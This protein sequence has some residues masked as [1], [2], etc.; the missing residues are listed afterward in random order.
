MFNIH[1][2]N[3]YAEFLQK[4]IEPLRPLRLVFDCSDGTTG[5]IISKLKFKNCEVK[6]INAE[7]DGNFPNHGPNP[8][9]PKAIRAL[10]A[11][12]KDFQA[13][14]GVIFD[15]DGDRAFFT[16]DK[17]HLINPDAIARLL[18]HYLKPQK[19]IIDVRTGWLAK[20]IPDKNIK[21]I[22]AKAGYISIKKT[23]IEQKAD[24]GVETSGHYF[25][26]FPNLDAKRLVSQPSST[27]RKTEKRFCFDSGVLTAITVINALSR[28]PYKLSDF[29][30]LLPLSYRPPE[31]NFRKPFLSSVK[32][33]QLLETIKS[34]FQKNALEISHLDGLTMEFADWWFN[35]RCSQ[36]ESC[37]RLNMETVNKQLFRKK[38]S[39]IA[40]FF[41][42]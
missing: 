34:H 36:T 25:F 7:P 32:F 14:L 6:I 2:L 33:P 3:L 41:K 16:D 30:A 26:V 17:N 1:W 20:N 28:L 35:L 31:I 8:S 12:V 42:K 40:K 27:H 9:K 23:I 19:A 13:D 10:I 18:L 4:F 11:A 15:G 39:R 5:L 29:V 24:F 21:L 22:I 37:L 38:F